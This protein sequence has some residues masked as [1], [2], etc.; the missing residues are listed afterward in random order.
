MV[1][2]EKRTSRK[3]NLNHWRVEGEVISWASIILMK[4]VKKRGKCFRKRQKLD[5]LRNAGLL[6]KEE[7]LLGN[8]KIIDYSRNATVKSYGF[9]L[10]SSLFYLSYDVHIFQFLRQDAC[11]R[12]MTEFPL[13]NTKT[14]EI[15]CELTL[16]L[17]I[18]HCFISGSEFPYSEHQTSLLLHFWKPWMSR[19]QNKNSLLTGFCLAICAQKPNKG[20]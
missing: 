3:T 11:Y 14:Y 13:A 4:K 17:L 20:M 16:M 2:K 8:I 7:N 5:F 1:R 15:F 6:K 18:Y 12:G 10:V 19:Y 9:L